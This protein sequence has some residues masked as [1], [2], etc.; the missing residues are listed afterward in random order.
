[1]KIGN[2]VTVALVCAFVF[3]AC[4]N[5][6]KDPVVKVGK[7]TIGKESLEA[8]KKVAGIYPAP[9]PHYFP[10]QRQPVTFMAECEAV[11]QNAKSKAAAINEKITSSRDWEW[12]K[13]YYTASLFFDL[14]GDNLG[15][16][17]SELEEYYKKNKESL[18]A[19]GKTESGEDS[20]FIPAFD[21]VKRQTADLL[22][23]EKYQPDSAFL[24]TLD[25][26]EYDSVAL[27]GRWLYH[28]RS[29]PADFFMRRFFLENT[30]EA[31]ADSVEQMY[32]EGKYINSDDIDVI[33]AWVPEN[34]R[35]M[36]MKE[37]VE[38]LYKW[39][40][41]SEHVTKKGMT[42][43]NAAF[44]DV[45]HWAMRVEFANT[46]LQDEVMPKLSAQTFETDTALAQFTIYDQTRQVETSP[47]TRVQAELDSIAKTRTAVAVDSVIYG[48]RKNVKIAFLQ[49]DWKDNRSENPSALL[50]KADSLR[51]AAA[52]D[53]LDMDAVVAMSEEAENLYRTLVNDFAFTAEGRKAF[54]ELAK[55]QI[56]KYN[57][58][59]RPEKYLLNQ[60]I[61]FY[62]RGQLLDSG[63][64]NLCNSFFM[65]GFT[66]DEYLKSYPL[67]EANYKWILRSAPTCALASDAEFM[68]QHLDEPMTSIEE[69]QGQSIRQGRK[70]DFDDATAADEEESE[71]PR[72]IL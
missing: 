37:L 8:F 62:R 24:A 55:I 26:Q 16:P 59:P 18:R 19:T 13:R 53:D 47:E 68:L 69:I 65:I 63:D 12:K 52:D 43:N 39:K 20:S 6:V 36:R 54:N 41:F 15:F 42:A 40:S 46:Y 10:A 11:Y 57:S 32:G 4:Q 21:A 38:W 22:F 5:K 30:G 67:A 31:Y 9:L 64:E 27:R 35:N 28:V 51:D 66:Y 23:Y 45:L 49:S 58:G 17:D 56:D 29:S 61:F 71:K 72:E 44:K 7:T 25:G 33:R 48:I 50:A 14:L 34:R 2:V 70:I 60:A 3:P 1:M